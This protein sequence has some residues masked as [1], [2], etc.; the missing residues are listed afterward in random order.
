[1]CMSKT[2]ALLSMMTMTKN[3]FLISDSSHSSNLSPNVAY[4][5]YTFSLST[6][7]GDANIIIVEC[8]GKIIRVDI[9]IGKAGSSVAAWCNAFSRMLTFALLH[10]L[11]FD[12]VIEELTDIATD[13][14]QYKDG[15]PIRSGPEA[16]A[17]ALRNLS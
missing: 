12:T 1:M 10:G 3:N 9:M 4:D 13:R 11:P 16:I 5:N 2:P 15:I 14:Y 17:I 8:E 6:P 7:D